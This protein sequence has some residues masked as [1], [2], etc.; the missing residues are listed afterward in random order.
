MEL[1][2][3]QEVFDEIKSRFE[4]SI[5]ENQFSTSYSLYKKIVDEL[6]NISYFNWTGIYLLNSTE[7]QLELEYYVGKPTEHTTIKV[8]VGVCGSAVTE[9]TDKIIADVRNEENYLA[10]SL[11][12]RSEI[13]VLIKNNHQ[14]IGQIDVDSDLVNAFNEIDHENLKDIANLIVKGLKTL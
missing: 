11:Q 13:V 12:T 9:N 5:L 4:K 10:C 1:K 2:L 8:G 6:A 7:D 14:I 3:K